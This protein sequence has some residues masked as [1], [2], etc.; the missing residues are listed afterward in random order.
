MNQW[1]L[2]SVSATFEQIGLYKNS[3]DGCVA[4][5]KNIFSDY[6]IFFFSF[7]DWRYSKRID[8]RRIMSKIY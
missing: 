5:A 1:W 7:L 6:Y 4:T 8:V 3:A 2:C